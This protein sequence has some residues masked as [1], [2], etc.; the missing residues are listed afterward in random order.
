M[1]SLQRLPSSQ[2]SEE[3]FL[4]SRGEL[5]DAEPPTPLIPGFSSLNPRRL[6]NIRL[7]HPSASSLYQRRMALLACNANTGA[8]GMSMVDPEGLSIPGLLTKGERSM[9]ASTAIT[10]TASS[11]GSPS[12]KA[13]T[14]AQAEP[15]MTL[16]MAANGGVADD[17]SAGA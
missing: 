16:L 1:L 3:S 12:C 15:P 13:A 4:L 17:P 10:S 14:G 7:E 8:K 2:S 5:P 9:S 6:T 11:G